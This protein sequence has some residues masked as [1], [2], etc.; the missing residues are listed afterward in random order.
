MTIWLVLSATAFSA[1]MLILLGLG[2]PKRRRSAGLNGSNG[3]ILRYLY[4]VSAM[5][6]GILLALTRDAAMWLIWFGGCAVAGWLIALCLAQSRSQHQ[7][8]NTR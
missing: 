8:R 3:Q 5:V 7:D 2:D 4:M 1:S 6:P